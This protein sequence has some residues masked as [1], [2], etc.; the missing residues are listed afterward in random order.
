MDGYR[1][2]AEPQNGC[3]VAAM[4]LRSAGRWSR[5]RSGPVTMPVRLDSPVVSVGAAAAGGGQGTPTM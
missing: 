4:G 5:S 2:L 1:S 3:R